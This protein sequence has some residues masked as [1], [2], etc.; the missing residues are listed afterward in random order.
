MATIGKSAGDRDRVELER[1]EL[2]DDGGDRLIAPAKSTQGAAIAVT[3]VSLPNRLVVDQVQFSPNPAR[4]RT[5]ITARFH[6]SDTR[7]F[8]NSGAL[9]YALGLPY[10]WVYPAAETATD[11][12][13]W[14]TISLQPTRNMPLRPDDLVLFVRARKPGDNILAASRREGWCRRG[15][16]KQGG[17]APPQAVP[18]PGRSTESRLAR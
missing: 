18:G 7:G 6:V 10:G 12:T 11:G 14:A 5:P 8:S 16:S 13:G 4:S 2:G 15:S 3:Q 9:V 17:L 1:L